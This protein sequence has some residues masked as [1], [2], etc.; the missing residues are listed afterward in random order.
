MSQQE[1]HPI[2]QRPAGGGQFAVLHALHLAPE[3]VPQ[4]L[5]A[6]FERCNVGGLERLANL[7]PTTVRNLNALPE[8][9]PVPEGRPGPDAVDQLQ[10]VLTDV[11][12]LG[13]S[14]AIGRGRRSGDDGRRNR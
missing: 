13:G 9:L 8:M 3:A 14:C 1:G 4:C 12:L 6:D 10:R 5:P 2:E 11:V 7:F